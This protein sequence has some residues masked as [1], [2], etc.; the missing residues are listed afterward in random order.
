M[1]GAG[2]PLSGQ[3]ALVTGGARGIGAAI[4]RRLA[5]A[6]AHVVV[7]YTS[8]ED[9]AKTLCAELGARA[10]RHKADVS[11]RGD[12][13]G[14]MTAILDAH[15]TLDIVVNNAGI[16]RDGLVASMR[17]ADWKR[18]LDVD[19]D[20]VFYCTQ[21]AIRHMIRTR[22]GAIVNVA[23]VSAIRGG[24]GQANYAAA[25]GAVVSFT[26]ACALE[27]AARGIRL[28]AVLPGLIDTDM[29]KTIRRRAGEEVLARIPTGRFGTPNDV[30]GLVAFL[31]GPEAAYITGQ[32]ICVDGGLS[33]A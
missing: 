5:A 7:N 20:G 16:V 27:V 3:V 11:S 18:V 14:M 31:C 23:S 24:R 8:S 26:R 17:D 13:E 21:R 4:S 29:T 2:A 19:L 10:S 1:N 9:A 28:N 22:A 32:A 12:V 6:G 15:D 30:A 33:V 25:K